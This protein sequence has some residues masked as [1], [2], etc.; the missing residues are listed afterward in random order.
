MGI[1]LN[2]GTKTSEEEESQRKRETALKAPR[3]NKTLI[4]FSIETNSKLLTPTVAIRDGWL[5]ST[6][7]RS[8]ALSIIWAVVASFYFQQCLQ[9]FFFLSLLPF[10]SQT[11]GARCLDARPWPIGS[12][13]LGGAWG[14]WWGCEGGVSER[15]L[16]IQLPSHQWRPGGFW[17]HDCCF[18]LERASLRPRGLKHQHVWNVAAFRPS[19]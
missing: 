14:R 7:I 9:P 4:M 19:E 5:P 3:R 2:S 6:F 8:P 16:G 12:S 13:Q 18:N 15:M 17:R 10:L 11:T 1:F